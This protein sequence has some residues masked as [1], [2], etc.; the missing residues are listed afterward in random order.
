[1]NYKPKFMVWVNFSLLFFGRCKDETA[2]AVVNR[3]A[4]HAL[5]LVWREAVTA[6]AHKPS[7][8][9]AV[10]VGWAMVGAFGL[11]ELV[12]H[13]HNAIDHA[14]KTAFDHDVQVG[15]FADEGLYGC[16]G[17]FLGHVYCS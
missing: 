6:L 16:E 13:G 8:L 11:V 4:H 1:V 10:G 3:D 15:R 17:D 9:D 14:I 12:G 2:A 7:A 5:V